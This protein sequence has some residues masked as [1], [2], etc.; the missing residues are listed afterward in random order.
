MSPLLDFIM[1]DRVR[2][3]KW[4]NPATGGTQTDYSPMPLEPSEDFPDVR[5]V[6]IQN[7]TSDDEVVAISRN[8]NNMT[9]KDG[10]NTE[11]TLTELLAGSGGLTE[12]THKILDSLVHEIAENAY[13]EYT[14]S[15]NKIS[16]IIIW[17]DTNK[18]TKI[19]EFSYVFANNKISTETAK[20]YDS[21]GD[22]LATLVATYAFSGNNIA[23]VTYVLTEV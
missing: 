9:F 19:R 23:S 8:A 20:Q 2:I 16:N 6:H 5:G 10:A 14:F 3:L 18:T 17:T 13:E 11:K 7:D 22:L 15:G 1:V 4:E 12:S 21:N